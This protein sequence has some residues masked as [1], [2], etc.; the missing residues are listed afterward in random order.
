[1]VKILEILTSFIKNLISILHC[2]ISK[3]VSPNEFK[4]NPVCGIIGSSLVLITLYFPE[5][6]TRRKRAKCQPTNT[7][8][9]FRW[10]EIPPYCDILL[11]EINNKI[12]CN[13]IIVF[14]PKI[15]TV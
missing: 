4:Q 1:M 5:N 13:F 7:T 8:E 12:K 2:Y 15:V 3:I 6:V 14:F 9:S 10:L 11:N